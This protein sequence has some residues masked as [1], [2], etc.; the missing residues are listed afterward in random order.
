M[1]REKRYEAM[2]YLPA[3]RKWVNLFTDRRTF[4]YERIAENR[5]AYFLTFFDIP[6]MRIRAV[7][8]KRVGT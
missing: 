7:W 5:A 3:E 1:K 2:A 6:Q 8:R 4:K